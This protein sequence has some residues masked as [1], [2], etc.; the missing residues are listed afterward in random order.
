MNTPNFPIDVVD[1][2]QSYSTYHA[3]SRIAAKV[4]KIRLG[5]LNFSELNEAVKKCIERKQWNKLGILV[6]V[7]GRN[8]L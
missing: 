3:P 5:V 7:L 6:D 2:F 1:L 8:Q 4:F